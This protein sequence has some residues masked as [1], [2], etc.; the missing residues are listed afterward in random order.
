MSI[1][2]KPTYPLWLRVWNFK[3]VAACRYDIFSWLLR[4]KS[5]HLDPHITK[6]ASASFNN[7]VLLSKSIMPTLESFPI[8][9]QTLFFI[10]CTNTVIKSDKKTIRGD[11][12]RGLF[13]RKALRKHEHERK[14][15]KNNS[16]GYNP[17]WRSR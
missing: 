2:M 3:R 1:T 10:P 11:F 8:H 16:V 17:A 5:F 13:A 4:S 6:T 12:R 14:H 9:E 7:K 15:L